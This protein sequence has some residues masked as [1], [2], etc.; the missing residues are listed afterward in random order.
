MLP[1]TLRITDCVMKGY[2]YNGTIA[3]NFTTFYGLYD[4]YYSHE[5]SYPW[6]ISEKWKNPDEDFQMSTPFNFVA[7]CDI[8]G[9]AS[10]SPVINQRAEVI[11]LAF[12]GNI[13]SIP[14]R[15]FVYY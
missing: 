10:G 3:P 9:G 4:R 15:F 12:D 7:T 14:C 5:K 6:D 1:F 8:T 2:E 11:G 13:E